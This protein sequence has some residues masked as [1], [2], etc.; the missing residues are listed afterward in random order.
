MSAA[1]PPRRERRADDAERELIQWKK[2]RFMADKVGDVFDGYITGVTHFGL[3]VELVDHY[4]EGLVH[5]SR[6]SDDFYRFVEGSHTLAGEHQAA[7]PA[8]RS[9]SG[10]DRACR[11][12]SPDDRPGAG[13]TAEQP[14]DEA[15]R[16]PLPQPDAPEEG[17]AQGDRDE[18]RPRRK[19]RPGKQERAQKKKR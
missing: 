15:L 11:H 10:A 18:R 12:G 9:R 8:R 14:R 13:E 5:V 3:F 7:L 19:Q 2:V 6:L 16:G 17:A 4:V 1:T